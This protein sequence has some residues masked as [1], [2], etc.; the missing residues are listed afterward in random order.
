MQY[1]MISYVVPLSVYP[2]TYNKQPLAYVSL[3]SQ[4]NYISL[5]LYNVY[6]DPNLLEWFENEFEKAGKKLNMA[7]SCVRFNR[8][9]QLPLDVIGRVVASTTA[10]QLIQLYEDSR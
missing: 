9:D 5:Y 1:G 10:E 3:A 7:K 2:N 6:A 8:L 4:K